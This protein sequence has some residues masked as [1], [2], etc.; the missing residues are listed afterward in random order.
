MA[1][2]K[3]HD[4]LINEIEPMETPEESATALM[5]GIAD[6]I[7]GCNGNKVKLSD[8]A[9]VLRENPNAIGKALVA[10]TPADRTK[11]KTT[12]S[13]SASSVFDK[14]VVKTN[15]Q[16]KAEKDAADKAAADKKTTEERADADR[17]AAAARQPAP[18]L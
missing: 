15:E 9:T 3:L 5:L 18:V 11:V 1:N 17:R 2:S 14:P 12:N 6:R 7:E 10:N 13:D 8:L 4:D 16:I